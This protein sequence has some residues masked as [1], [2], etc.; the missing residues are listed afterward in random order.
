[1]MQ[2][3]ARTKFMSFALRVPTNWQQPSGDPDAQQY[4]DAFKSDEKATSPGAPPLF[5]PASLNKYHT[6]T[7]K[8]LISTYGNFIDNMCSAICSAWSDWQT[9]ATMAGFIVTGPVVSGGQIIGPPLQPL[10]LAGGAPMST[11]MQMKYSNTIATVISTAWMTFTATVTAAA[12]PWFP[13]YAA[14]VTPVAPPMPNIPTPFAMLVQVPVSIS[15][16]V[17]KMQM[18]AQYADPT[19]PFASELFESISFA[20]EQCYNV[21]KLSTMVNNVMAIA[22]GGTPIS[23]LPA[24]GT[25]MMTPGGFT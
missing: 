2:Q 20:F 13:A 14:L 16:D 3:L 8:M 9:A 17:L 12:M 4:N 7:Q 1:M 6:D 22:T 25:A 18:V 5:I 10:I 11:P 15:A 19:A 21:W 23:P 24:T